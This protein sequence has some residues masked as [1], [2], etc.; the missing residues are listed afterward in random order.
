MSDITAKIDEAGK[1]D[2][3]LKAMTIRLKELKVDLADYFRETGV[4]KEE[5][6]KY[7]VTFSVTPKYSEIDP[8]ECHT[9]LEQ[10]GHGARLLEVVKIQVTPL[11][12]FLSGEEVDSLRDKTGE[13]VNVKLGIL[14]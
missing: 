10:R 3:N 2:K 11:K 4:K 14:K 1:L 5:G 6:A 13:T 7:G 12:K 9:L 8:V